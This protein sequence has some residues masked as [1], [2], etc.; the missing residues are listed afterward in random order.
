[1]M[2]TRLVSKRCSLYLGSWNFK[3]VARFSIVVCWF[4]VVSPGSSSLGIGIVFIKCHD[5]I[6]LGQ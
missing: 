3:R 6:Q 4:C 2:V 5:F 1:M